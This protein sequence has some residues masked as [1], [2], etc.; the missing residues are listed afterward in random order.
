[1]ATK[2]HNWDG[3]TSLGDHSL[4]KHQI[5]AQYF[6]AYL[7]ERCK[8]PIARSFRL[9]VVDAFSGAGRYS[10]GNLG[11]P[12]IFAETLLNTVRKI[13]ERRSADGM[14]K[15]DV[16]CLLVFNDVDQMAI[17]LLEKEIAPFLAMSQEYDSNVNMEVEYFQGKFEELVDQFENR[18]NESRCRN[19][20]YNLDQYGY[21]HVNRSTIIRLINSRR[22][23]EIFLTYAIEA[24]ITFLSPKDI[25]LLNKR[26]RIVDITID[27]K[28]PSK[29]PDP[30][31]QK[32]EWLGAM[33]RMIFDHFKG[34]APYI[35]PFS[36]HNPVGWRYWLMHFATSHRA[37]QVYND[38]LHKNSSPQAH[39]S[40]PQAHVGRAGLDMLAYNPR[41]EE[42]L[43]Y[44]FNDDSREYSRSQLPDDV[45]KIVYESGDVIMMDDFYRI[46]YNATPAHS[47][48]I[49]GAIIENRNLEIITPSGR[50]RRKAGRISLDDALRLARQP[51]FDLFKY[52]T[53]MAS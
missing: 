40:S 30:L 28:R 10:D 7:E 26:L 20:I 36:I 12:T 13:N 4:R 34:C 3:E 6:D 2:H 11:S 14:P 53:K 51:T 49:N 29:I 8:N 41:D 32:K 52:P 33:E 35:T 24:F 1:M 15:I 42:G 38:V 27:T 23:V 31:F 18:V 17:S 50:P 44:L 5:L 16:Y 47:E 37:R 46:A 48:D 9:A 22:S 39:D 25:A 45:E 19:V 43:L 21:S